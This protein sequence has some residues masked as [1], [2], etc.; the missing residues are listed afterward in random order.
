MKQPA[1]LAV[2]GFR[3]GYGAA[4]IVVPE[5]VT[6][7]WLGPLDDASKVA[8]RGLGGREVAV[9]GLAIAAA[10]RGKPLAPWLLASIAGDLNDIVAT[11]AGRKGIPDG[12][13]AKTAVVAGSSAALTAAILATT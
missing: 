1:V 3:V 7:N 9:H 8:L 5:K 6:K 12:A 11:F 10:L 2:L 13:P 4:L